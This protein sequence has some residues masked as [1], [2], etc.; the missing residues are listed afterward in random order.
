M[1]GKGRS[2]FISA[3]MILTI[4][5]AVIVLLANIGAFGEEVR[6]SEFAKW[7]IGGVLAEI[8]V[9]TIAAFRLEI[10]PPRNMLMIFNLKSSSISGTN[11]ERCSYEIKDTKGKQVDE[12]KNIPIGRADK[13]GW[14]Q[15]YITIPPKMSHMYLTTMTLEDDQGNK[16]LAKDYL[17]Q[18][19]LEV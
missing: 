16:Y 12:G 3:F 11:L 6:L 13:S 17:L 19:T 7:G 10:S 2:L 14:F 1:A 18:H 4:I 5:T 15:C 8:V 9:A